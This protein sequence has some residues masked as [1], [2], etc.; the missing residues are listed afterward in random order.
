MRTC[1]EA[2]GIVEKAILCRIFK[3]SPK[4]LDD[5][6]WDVVEGMNVVYQEVIKKDPLALLM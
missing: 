2:N 1:V 4:Q 6:D 3:C 5:M